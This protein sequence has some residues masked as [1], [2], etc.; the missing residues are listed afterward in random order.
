MPLLLA[1]NALAPLLGA[2]ALRWAAPRWG[3]PPWMVGSLG[4]PEALFPRVCATITRLF[5]SEGIAA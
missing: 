2:T 3:V 4:G 1:A 5:P